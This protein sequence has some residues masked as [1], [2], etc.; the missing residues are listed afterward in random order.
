MSATL[1]RNEVMVSAEDLT[2]IRHEVKKHMAEANGFAAVFAN[3]EMC[4]LPQELSA[5]INLGLQSLATNG[6]VSVARLPEE[7][8]STTAADIPGISRPTMLKLARERQIDSFKVGSHR[9]FKRDAVLEFKEQRELTR[10]EAMHALLHA[11]GQL[12]G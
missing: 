7:L 1:L 10:R 3:G 9:R 5:I 12:D 4:E 8:T 2:S 6:S 11:E